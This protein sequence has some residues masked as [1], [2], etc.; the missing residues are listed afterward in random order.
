MSMKLSFL[1][2]PL[3]KAEVLQEENYNEIEN[4]TGNQITNF[5][6]PMVPKTRDFLHGAFDNSRPGENP[7]KLLHGTTTLSFIYKGG[8][9]VAVDSR[10]TQGQYIA[11]Q[12]VQKVIE[13]N[14]FMLGTMAGGAAD[15]QYWEREL[16]RRTRLFQ[17]KNKER[18]SIAA[19]SKILAN[20]MY[21][22]RDYGLSLGC[23]VCG[24]D[25]RGPNI[26]YVD[27][28]GTRLKGQRFSVGSGSTFAYGVLDSEY[29][30]DLEKEEA[31]ELGQRAIYGATHRDA[32]SGGV[33][34]L[35]HIDENGWKK[36]S[37]IDNDDLHWTR[38]GKEVKYGLVKPVTS[39]DN[40]N[41]NNNNRQ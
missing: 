30:Y 24:W 17:L 36:I 9:V 41:N 2:E 32:Y 27:N 25:K 23:M 13:I 28:D 40:N 11:S 21:Y 22:Y 6:L 5:T 39:Q 29:K 7:I 31:L 14:P 19:A 16:G 4:I 20:I 8:I 18:M 34:N 35:Y 1:D 3:S 33:I 26:Y 37:S 15:C 38:Y 10:A 12:S